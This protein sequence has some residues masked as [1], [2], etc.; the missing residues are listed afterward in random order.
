MRE[1][2][3][4]IELITVKWGEIM[5]AGV[6]IAVMIASVTETET[7]LGTMIQ[8]VTGDRVH[9]QEKGQGIMIA[10]GLYFFH[11]AYCIIYI[12][13]ALAMSN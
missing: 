7:A 5:I 11:K 1:N 8:E 10:T 3:A 9:G 6:K 4:G 13:Y 2:Q 12:M